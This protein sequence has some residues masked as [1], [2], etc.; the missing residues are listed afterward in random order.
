MTLAQYFD[1]AGRG[2]Q[3]KMAKALGCSKGYLSDIANSKKLPSRDFALSIERYTKR[4]VKAVTLLEL[5]AA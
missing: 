5:K 1:K 2:S 3:A 4:K